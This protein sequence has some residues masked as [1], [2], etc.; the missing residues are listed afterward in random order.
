MTNLKGIK[1][2]SREERWSVVEQLIPLWKSKFGDNLLGI[3]VSAS[4]ARGEDNLYSDLELDVFL[5]EKPEDRP[6]QYLQRVVD[7]ML[8]EAIYHTPAEF[9]HDRSSIQPHWYLSASD[10]WLVVYNQPFFDDLQKKLESVQHGKN[11]F[12]RAATQERYEFQESFCKVLNAVE[13]RN[14]E[15]ISLL[16]MDACLHLL[17]MLAFINQEPFVTFSRFI[18]QARRF[19]I[20]PVRMDDFLDILVNGD[21]QDLTRVREI[22][23]DVFK[24]IEEIFRQNGV[25]LYDDELDPNLPNRPMLDP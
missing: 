1:P 10:R 15:G 20:K 9:I 19:A 16:L 4:V 11:N 6:D 3:A 7:G 18:S 25:E 17:K 12:I 5:R 23:L 2:H 21:Y 13:E 22:F 8:V 24:S 14:V